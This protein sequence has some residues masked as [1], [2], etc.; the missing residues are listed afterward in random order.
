M[1]VCCCWINCFISPVNEF[2]LLIIIFWLVMISSILGSLPSC[3]KG[4]GLLFREF[5][6]S[7]K[8]NFRMSLHPDRT[9]VSEYHI[10]KIVLGPTCFQA[11]VQSRYSVFFGPL[12][13][14]PSFFL[15]LFMVTS[16][17]LRPNSLCNFL[18]ISKKYRLSI[19]N[20]ESNNLAVS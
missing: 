8:T 12:L 2:R 19:V 6:N 10:G 4:A 20:T 9:L 14:Q 1:L 11:K 15:A 3:V 16:D 17:T 13:I 7:P 5:P 18:Q